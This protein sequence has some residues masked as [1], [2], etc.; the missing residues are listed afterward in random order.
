MAQ[1]S[2]EVSRVDA[3][4]DQAGLPRHFGRIHW[5]SYKRPGDAWIRRRA[6]DEHG[7]QL[8]TPVNPY[9]ASELTISIRDGLTRRYDYILPCATLFSNVVNVCC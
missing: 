9:T 1:K 7:L 4:G 8:A 6:V 3:G 5:V 2:V